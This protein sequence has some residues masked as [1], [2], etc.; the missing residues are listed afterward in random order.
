MGR[1]EA[2]RRSKQK[3]EGSPAKQPKSQPRNGPQVSHPAPFFGGIV[4]L[5]IA[6]AMSGMLVLEHV[7]GLSLPGCG[8][9]SPCALAAAS[10]WGKVPL[11]HWPVSFLGFAYFLGA[12][13][14]WIFSRAGVPAAFRWLVRLGMLVS[15]GF[16]CV[17]IFGK[18]S[19]PY[20]II[21]HACNFAFWVCVELSRKTPAA[22]MRP[23]TITAGAFIAVTVVLGAVNWQTQKAADRKQE[24]LLADSTAEVANA[25][26]TTA[27]TTTPPVTTAVPAAAT[28]PE[29][30]LFPQ[31]FTGRYREGPEKAPVRLVMLTDFQC[32]DC[33]RIEK[34]VRKMMSERND[35]SLSIKN[36]PMCADCNDAFKTQNMHPNACWAARAAEAAGI[37]RGNDGFWQMHHWLFDRQGAFTD[38]ELKQG[39]IELGY[40]PAEFIKVMMSPETLRLVKADIAEGILLGLHFTPMVFINGVEL[41]GVFAP[42]AI[43]RAVAAVAAKN[44]PP[45]TAANDHPPPALEKCVSDWREAPVSPMPSSSF[46]WPRGPDNA[47]IKVVM[48][49]DYQER[50]TPKADGII[51]K[52]MAGR[53][54]V[55]YVFRNFPFNQACNTIVKSSPHALACRAAQAAEAAG[56]LAGVDGYWKMHDWLMDHQAKFNDDALRKAA[57]GMGFNA[58]TLLATMDSPEVKAAIEEDVRTGNAMLYR[59]GIP[60]IY[61]NGKVIP[62]WQIDNRP[63][64]EQILKEAA[65]N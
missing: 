5:L 46:S 57:A 42:Q 7:W 45:A 22:S 64:L 44:P 3:R 14:A 41:K 12:L 17:I 29:Q 18:Y 43:P 19:C 50:E 55:Q 48:W 60:T 2:D 62:R 58:D 26:T 10:V 40:D 21:S 35:V 32:T 37:L 63:A 4:F 28:Q 15:L 20:C 56:R 23:L 33:N 16:V 59:G 34:D 8:K 27:Q 54:D 30:E 6:S 52:W 31:G 53:T 24:T 38:A 39:L 47:R 49:S 25:A 51:C 61:V 65:Q 1:R 11:I 9:G 36:F 13:V